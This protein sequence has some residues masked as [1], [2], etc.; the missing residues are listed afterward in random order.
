M[1]AYSTDAHL[2]Q[3]CEMLIIDV[4]NADESIGNIFSCVAVDNNEI[5]LCL[6]LYINNN[7]IN[8]N[9]VVTLWQ[10]LFYM[11]TKIKI[12]KV[13]GKFKSGQLHERHV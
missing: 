9:W 6:F 13:T 11:Y 8:C 12:K 7:N 10:W 1:A 2:G 5:F 4:R 3:Q